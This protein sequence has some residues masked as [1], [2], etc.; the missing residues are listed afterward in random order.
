MGV[1]AQ[2][3]SSRNFPDF[4]TPVIFLS[5]PDA[6]DCLGIFSARKNILRCLSDSIGLDKKLQKKLVLALHFINNH[7]IMGLNL[8]YLFI[9][10]KRHFFTMF[11]G[12][13]FLQ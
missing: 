3:L 8:K 10:A 4:A 7:I 11:L 9:D 6:F 12:I 2:T 1:C 13:L 5:S